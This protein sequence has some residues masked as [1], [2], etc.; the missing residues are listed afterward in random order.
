MV[1][2][3]EVS[4][5]SR[6][7]GNVCSVIAQ[8]PPFSLPYGVAYPILQCALFFGG[9][10]GIYVF[11][12][13]TGNSIA[14]FWGGAGAV[15][16]RLQGCPGRVQ[17]VQSVA[18]LHLQWSF[19]LAGALTL[20]AGVVLLGLYGPGAGWE[21]QDD[22]TCCRY[23]VIFKSWWTS[24]WAKQLDIEEC[25]KAPCFLR[26]QQKTALWQGQSRN[27]PPRYQEMARGFRIILAWRKRSFLSLS[28]EKWWES[29]QYHFKMTPRVGSNSFIGDI[30][31]LHKCITFCAFP[32]K[33]STEAVP[34]RIKKA[35]AS[36]E[37]WQGL[38]HWKP[39]QTHLCF[40]FSENG[41]YL[42]PQSPAS[43]LKIEHERRHNI[44]KQA[45]HWRTGHKPWSIERGCQ[46]TP[47]FRYV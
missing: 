8:S 14:V 37:K 27:D 7:T 25:S 5:T 36:G 47:F 24:K 1:P 40:S 6:A 23:T 18:S 43:R 20:V 19:V 16:W 46:D 42:V 12:E 35:A 32:C 26:H 39:D 38:A 2:S 28:G 30:G 45:G 22:C 10:W 34:S 17:S 44:A 11:K 21:W 41:G 4:R 9:L 29:L 3:C 31:G 33:D 13:I 15:Q